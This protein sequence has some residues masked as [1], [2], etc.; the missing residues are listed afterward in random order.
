LCGQ[1]LAHPHVAGHANTY[2]LSLYI[3]HMQNTQ[4]LALGGWLNVPPILWIRFLILT[5]FTNTQKNL[6]VI[7]N[8]NIMWI[9][10]ICWELNFVLKQA[11]SHIFTQYSTFAQSI[12]SRS[13]SPV[14]LIKDSFN[15]PKVNLTSVYW[16]GKARRIWSS[17]KL[18]MSFWELHFFLLD[19]FLIELFPVIESWNHRTLWFKGTLKII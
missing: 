18:T 12:F 1:I 11:K 14:V 19:H 9:I 8:S 6:G 4:L 17:Y 16:W 13:C 2:S 3:S 10:Y 5:S 15:I 7:T